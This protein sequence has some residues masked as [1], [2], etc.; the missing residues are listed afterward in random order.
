MGYNRQGWFGSPAISRT[1]G[2]RLTATEPPNLTELSEK[3]VWNVLDIVRKEFNVD[4]DRV[5]LLGHSMGGAGALFPGAK[6]VSTWAAVAALSPATSPDILSP[7]ILEPVK[8]TLPLLLMHGDAD[9]LV[10]VANARRWNQAILGLK[11]TN[12]TYLE[13]PGA[14]HNGVVA[15]AM[16][17]VFKFFSQHNRPTSR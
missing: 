13:V 10:P 2:K 4:E 1:D 16:R 7:A 17:E 9:Q 15:L 12:Y 14:D 8:N 5:Y 11:M 6:H 3:D